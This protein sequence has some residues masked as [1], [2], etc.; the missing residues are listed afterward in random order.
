MF[1]NGLRSSEAIVLRSLASLNYKLG[2]TKQGLDYCEQALRLATELKI[3]LIKDCLDLKAL[4]TTSV[5]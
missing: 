4:L 1:T 2:Q 3:P 5:L